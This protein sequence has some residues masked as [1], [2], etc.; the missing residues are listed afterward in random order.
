MG[1][2]ALAAAAGAQ[3]DL[4]D[5]EQLRQAG[6]ARYWEMD[7]RLMPDESLV[8]L[9][10]VDDNLYAITSRG[11]VYCLRA[12]AG[13]I[14]FS[15]NI[16]RSG[17]RLHHPTHWGQEAY[18]ASGKEIVALNR[19]SGV[20]RFRWKLDFLVSNPAI[21][22]Q[23]QLYV[24]SYSGRL[25]AIR[26]ADCLPM[27]SVRVAE[28]ISSAAAQLEAVVFMASQDR[29]V[30][31][32]RTE[33]KRR[34]WMTRAA[35]P[36]F[37]DLVIDKTG[38]YVPSMDRLLY[39]LDPASG[40]VKW[41]LRTGGPLPSR[42][43]VRGEVCY[44][45]SE[46]AGV[47]AASTADGQLRW[48]YP[49]GTAFLADLGSG[50]LVLAKEGELHRLAP[51][52]GQLLGRCRAEGVELVAPSATLQAG[53]VAAADGRVLCIRSVEQPYLTRQRLGELV[54]EGQASE[55]ESLL[56][57]SPAPQEQI[58]AEQAANPLASPSASPPLVGRDY[59]P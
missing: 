38:L 29:T 28:T 10:L 43:W 14:R 12:D 32:R 41:R 46:A 40:S 20:E 19:H 51:D 5:A 53:F 45:A 17:Y 13:L 58:P 6:L 16:N 34:L 26:K 9:A 27:W 56:P 42:P 25:Y 52:D 22:D 54:A 24:A 2:L 31:A 55:Q 48:V 18:F 15:V 44:I 39:C 11:N 57:G 50:I 33:D 1:L 3:T 21:A 30:Q 7:L 23:G 59:E 8:D 37:A 4:V 35:G 47:Y 36:I 49:S